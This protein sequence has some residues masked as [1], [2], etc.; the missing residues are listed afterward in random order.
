MIDLS[1]APMDR[2]L[3][4]TT[5][6][7]PYQPVRLHYTIPSKAFVTRI[8]SRLGCV[9][10]DRANARWGWLYM[11]EAEA[12]T[13]SRPRA[14]LPDEVHPVLIGTLRFPKSGGMMLEVR[15]TA[16]AIEAARFFGALF[17]PR[18]V[19]RRLRIVNRLFD[20]SELTSG[21]DALDRHL[22]R[23]VTVI[24]PRESEE[25]LNRYLAGAR[26]PEERA[27][28]R[29]RYH[30]DRRRERRDIPLVE[31]FPLAPEEETPDFQHL[32]MTLQLRAIR[33][34]EHWAGNT[35]LILAD[36]IEKLAEQIA[37]KMPG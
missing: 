17:G 28:A 4:V 10:E 8:L 11:A 27:A 36:I 2:A 24:D 29:E 32:A 7:E 20:A 25:R 31:D 1:P 34:W 22:D 12:L 23:N 26:T 14:E 33:A 9:A 35:Q 30:Q 6:G 19:L 16:R 21:L 3:L 15:S 13:F 37:A 18:V 5:T